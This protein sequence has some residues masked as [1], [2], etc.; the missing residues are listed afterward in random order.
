LASAP[1]TFTGTI[2]VDK[3][4]MKDAEANQEKE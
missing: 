2:Q 3:Q 1:K 4:A